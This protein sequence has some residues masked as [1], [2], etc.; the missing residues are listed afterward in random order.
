VTK[1]EDPSGFWE[2]VHG[3]VDLRDVMWYFLLEI[4]TFWTATPSL[5]FEVEILIRV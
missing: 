4:R 1:I 3:R 2:G 5:W